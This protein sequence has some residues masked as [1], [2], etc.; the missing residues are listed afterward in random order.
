MKDVIIAL[1]VGGEHFETTRSTLCGRAIEP[2]GT[3]LSAMFGGGALPTRLDS[4][5]RVFIDRD[6]SRFRMVLN[7]LRSGALVGAVLGPATLEEMLEE[8]EYFGMQRLVQ[9]LRDEIAE[10]QLEEDLEALEASQMS[11]SQQSQPADESGPKLEPEMIFSISSP[12]S[13]PQQTLAFPSKLEEKGM[14][15]A[16]TSGTSP[17]D[18]IFTLNAD[19]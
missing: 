8:A 9:I 4:A 7:Y 2:H 6:G 5:G 13:S 14:N 1:N 11:L 10:Q 3:M 16:A 18:H 15:A 17:F 19:F 12:A